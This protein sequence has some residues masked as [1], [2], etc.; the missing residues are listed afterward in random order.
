MGSSLKTLSR[1]DLVEINRRMIQAFGGVYFPQ[2][3]N[4]LF[5]G[6]LEHIFDAIQ[7]MIFNVDQYPTVF[8]KAAGLAWRIIVGH[9]FHDGNKRTGME[10]CRL[11]LEIN[12]Y[13]MKI[14][15][16]VVHIALK[17]ARKELEFQEFVSWIIERSN[18]IL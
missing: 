7:G 3:Q 5:P 16:G 15:F 1:D 4:L 8:E 13:E 14:D 2:D 12:G 9:V 6:S 17:I 18:K 11:F 10:A